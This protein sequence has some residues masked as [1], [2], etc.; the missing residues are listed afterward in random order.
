MGSEYFIK[1][2]SGDM[3]NDSGKNTSPRFEIQPVHDDDK[4][5]HT[6]HKVETINPTTLNQVAM[7]IIVNE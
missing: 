2:T 6:Q 5:E 4:G 3:K 7:V 1:V